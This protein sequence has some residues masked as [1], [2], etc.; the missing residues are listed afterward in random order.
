MSFNFSAGKDEW[1]VCQ[2]AGAAGFEPTHHGIKIR[3][4]TDLAMP[5]HEKNDIITILFF[6][7]GY[8]RL[9]GTSVE[10]YRVR[11]GCHVILICTVYDH[12]GENVDP[13][14]NEEIRLVDSIVRIAVSH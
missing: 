14:V 2:M 8:I 11:N 4:L 7:T 6:Q 9:F 3:C 5:P 12:R 10:S 1:L 13:V